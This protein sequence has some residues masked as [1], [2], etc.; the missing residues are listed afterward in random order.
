MREVCLPQ[1]VLVQLLQHV[2]QDHRLSSCALVSQNWS[3]AA[4]QAT[5]DIWLWSDARTL[6]GLQQ[7]LELKQ[8]GGHVTSLHFSDDEY[9]YRYSGDGLE[10][11]VV[12]LAALPC[13]KLQ[14]LDLSSHSFPVQLGPS[15]S[16]PGLLQA[17]TGLTRLCLRF[18]QDHLLVGGV[19]SLVQI[20]TLA[21]LRHLDVAY[22]DSTNDR[23]T[24][25][26]TDTCPSDIVPSS[27]LR[28][29][30]G[31]THLGLS[32]LITL[33]SMQALNGLTQVS[34]PGILPVT[35]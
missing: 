7:W 3:Q 23:W 29:M 19:Q 12:T 33:D 28:Q 35:P 4:A 31:L 10:R 25:H 32:G 15:T 6:S 11:Y 17:V 27:L 34:S 14:Y 20:S 26:C 9:C 16:Q 2:P 8:H 22:D 13:P 1:N 18:E 24:H 30:T 5:A 21:C